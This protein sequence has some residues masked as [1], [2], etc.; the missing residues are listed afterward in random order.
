MVVQQLE[1]PEKN[2][3]FDLNKLKTLIEAYITNHNAYNRMIMTGICL[4]VF[5]KHWP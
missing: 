3:P 5:I 1:N 2:F 4:V